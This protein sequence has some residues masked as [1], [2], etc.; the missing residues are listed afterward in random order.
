LALSCGVAAAQ[1]PPPKDPAK[2]PPVDE[3]EAAA[4]ALRRLLGLKPGPAKDTQVRMPQEQPSGPPP[5][6]GFRFA[7]ALPPPLHGPPPP[8][9]MV[10]QPVVEEPPR[11]LEALAEP[12]RAGDALRRLL[13]G[14]KPVTE[15]PREPASP[16]DQGRERPADEADRAADVFG[17][18]GGS[19]AAD[20]E[21]PGPFA[22]RGS[23]STRYR[24]RAVGS[25]TDQE[26]TA[27]LSLAAGEAGR[28]PFSLHLA[29]RGYAD[30]DGAESSRLRGIEDSYGD[31]LTGRLYQAHL[32]LHVVPG[33][34]VA[35]A[36]RQTVDDA[37]VH[38]HLDGA[39]L[40]TAPLGS[41]NVWASAYVGL[42][43]HLFESSRSGDFVAGFAAGAVPWAQ[44]R[45][46]V[47]WLHL[48]DRLRT[49]TR[50]DDLLGLGLW[51]GLGSG[52][53]LH[54]GHTRLGSDAR[55]VTVRLHTDFGACGLRARVAWYQL[56]ETQ[57]A[58]VTELDPFFE[59]LLEYEP[60]H[61]LSFGID[62]DLG[63][64]FGLTAGA[65]VRRLRD[66]QDDRPFN[67]EF[68]RWYAGPTARGLFGGALAASLTAELWHTEGERIE[69]LAADVEWGLA[70]TT[71]L[72]A[73]TSYVL[74]KLDLLSGVERD[75]VRTYAVRLTHRLGKAL[76]FD[77][78]YEIEDAD[79]AG[80]QTFTAG[81]TW[82]F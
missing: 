78:R 77:L 51:Q 12:E 20:R 81:M 61:Q 69:T 22:V 53:T 48:E 59:A 15:L 62:Q 40:E 25:E 3:S 60:Y 72:G 33:L 32:D 73:G 65:E 39:R 35:R 47:D 68:E 23:L 44:G 11:R 50:Q 71:T 74:Y 82:K 36:G 34:A 58:L 14:A 66:R 55:D 80:F 1:D 17:P 49:G 28:D 57:R 56:L 30:L 27:L 16:Q 42:P 21:A 46:R 31:A 5:P 70:E 18:P 37:P 41:A 75:H 38:L 7:A 63:D 8:P 67:R 4:E 2:P 6:P 24:L 45:L 43:V 10:P 13:P 29:G 54:L 76:R 26:A 52:S 79:L 19:A 9:G 64:H